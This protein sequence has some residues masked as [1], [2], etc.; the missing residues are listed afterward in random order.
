MRIIALSDTMVRIEII[1]TS[2]NPIEK[3]AR[4]DFVLVLV[5]MRATFA[6]AIHTP[7]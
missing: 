5:L 6:I 3:R 1:D 4:L 2:L 7:G